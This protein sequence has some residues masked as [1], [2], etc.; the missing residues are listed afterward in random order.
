MTRILHRSALI[1]A[2]IVLIANPASAVVQNQTPA[3]EPCVYETI[4]ACFHDGDWWYDN[5]NIQG[6]L[7]FRDLDCGLSGGCKTCGTSSQGKPVCVT[8]TMDAKCSCATDPVPGGAPN[9]VYCS[10][11]GTC[12]FRG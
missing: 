10:D 9:I 2:A 8:V 6:G 5:A 7:I 3:D 4:D 11:A 12:K 1:V